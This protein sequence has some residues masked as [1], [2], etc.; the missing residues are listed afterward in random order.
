MQKEELIC[1]RWSFPAD[2][3]EKRTAEVRKEGEKEKCKG[4]PRK[5]GE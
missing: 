3:S 5:D 2:R 1:S 4:F